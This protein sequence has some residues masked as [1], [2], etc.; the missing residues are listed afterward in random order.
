VTPI[1]LDDLLKRPASSIERDDQRVDSKIRA[2]NAMRSKPSSQ[3]NRGFIRRRVRAARFRERLAACFLSNLDSALPSRGRV[4]R[5]QSRSYLNRPRTKYRIPVIRQS[6]RT[7]S[8][9]VIEPAFFD[10]RLPADRDSAAAGAPSGRSVASVTERDLS[11]EPRR[12]LHPRDQCAIDV[13]RS[14]ARNRLGCNVY[15]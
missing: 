9:G 10:S 14:T 4:K 15:V 5:R 13:M 6:R 3:P 1:S 7:G 12:R 2:S 8:A 11:D